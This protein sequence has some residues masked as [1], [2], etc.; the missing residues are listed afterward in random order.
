MLLR[1]GSAV[2]VHREDPADETLRLQDIDDLFS[3]KIA[4]GVSAIRFDASSLLPEE[5][6]I[7]ANAGQQRTNEFATGRM[8]ARRLLAR[9]GREDFALLQ[10]PDRLPIW[11]DGLIGSIS[12]K[13]TICI[14]A[15]AAAEDRA[16][17]GIDVEPDRPVRPG[18][19][20]RICRPNEL[21]W[22]GDAE[23]EAEASRRCRMIFSVKEAV[24]KAFY[25]RQREVWEF[26]QVGVELDPIRGR[27]RAELPA[28]AVREYVDGVILRR[29][30]WLVAGVEWG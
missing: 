18:V 2:K 27:F 13:Q 15:V 6:A 7:V 20:R 9:F 1:E 8:L 19:E 25:P 4:V 22:V 10:D 21:E 30:G 11:P 26:Q 14:V 29:R 12:H 24:Y 23:D 3:A 5:L 28:S 16:G 17:V